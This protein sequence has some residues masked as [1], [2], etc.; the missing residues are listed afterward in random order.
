MDLNSF[1]TLIKQEN[2]DGSGLNVSIKANEKLNDRQVRKLTLVAYSASGEIKTGILWY[3]NQ[4]NVV[5]KQQ[6]PDNAIDELTN[7]KV[8]KVSVTKKEKQETKQIF[9]EFLK[10]LP[11]NTK[12]IS[13]KPITTQL[14]FLILVAF[15][16]LSIMIAL[17]FSDI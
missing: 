11:K 16:I 12:I 9:F 10:E 6:Y 13:I 3:D 7:I 15:P 4:L 17:N 14:F 2:S 8:T 1:E 5:I